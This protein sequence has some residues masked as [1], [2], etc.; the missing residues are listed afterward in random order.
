[1]GEPITSVAI[2]SVSVSFD[3]HATMRDGVQLA[4]DVYTPASGKGPWPVL[5]MRTPYGKNTYTEN[6][7]SGFDPVTA[8]RAGFIVVIQDTRGRGPVT[9]G[10]APLTD[11][12]HD[13][14]D[15]IDWAAKLPGS[16]GRVG[17]FGGSYSGHTQ[18]QAALSGAPALGAITP[19]M[20]WADPFDGVYARGGATELGLALPWTLL[21]GAD[22][23][24]RRYA[25]TGSEG[26]RLEAIFDVVDRLGADGFWRGR[27]GT[28][29]M[30]QDHDVRELGSL[31]VALHGADEVE[32]ADLSGRQSAAQIPTFHTGGW[33]DIFLQGTLDNHAA[34]VAAGLPAR[35]IVGPWSHTSFADA[36][37]ELTFGIRA[38][39]EM[40][41]V[42]PAGAWIDSQLSWLRQHLDSGAGE[43]DLSDDPPVRV[44]VMGRNEWR[45][46]PQWPPADARDV[47]WY[48]H[49]AGALSPRSPEADVTG[50]TYTYDL[51][52]PVPTVGGNTF[53]TSEFPAGPL[54]QRGIE[55]RSDV[56]TFTSEV[57]DVDLEIGGRV[58][59]YPHAAGSALTTD[60]VVRLCDVHPD[61]RSFNVCDGVLRVR[62]NS[63]PGPHHIGLWSTSMVFVAGHRIRVDIANSSFPRWDRAPAGDADTRYRVE[64]A[65]ISVDRDRPSWI[66]LPTRT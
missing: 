62:G 38:G 51:S 55:S 20:T 34:M 21:T 8:A 60:W 45:S 12:A 59:A 27:A 43:P 14:A 36:V 64:R 25:G 47:A 30:L 44:F 49:G 32:R 40:P 41:S 19:L 66:V 65:E 57:L 13:G 54:D 6:A 7:W 28:V 37:G 5:M 4:A 9:T 10:G 52:D 15:A 48:L 2:T 39:R 16:N 50:L 46:E 33:F 61:G 58:Q 24:Y 56:V 23:V 35:L 17:M 29:T 11:D 42:H 22:D 31:R 63:A 26:D 53:I 3:V 18:W 1:M